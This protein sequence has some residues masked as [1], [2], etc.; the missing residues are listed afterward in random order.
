MSILCCESSSYVVLQLS[1]PGFAMQDAA[2]C[3]QQV[4]KLDRSNRTA[5]DGLVECQGKLNLCRQYRSSSD[6]A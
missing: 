1:L 3:M 2:E 5:A 4:L 6:Q